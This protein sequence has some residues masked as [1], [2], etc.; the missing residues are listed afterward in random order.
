MAERRM[1]AASIVESDA[2]RMM[3]IDAQALYFH[4]NSSADDDGFVNNVI[5]IQRAIGA[6]PEAVGELVDRKFLISFPSGVYVIKHWLINN[7]IR[8]DRY[9]KTTYTK[10]MA[11]LE[12]E[13]G[14]KSY[15]IIHHEEPTGIPN[16][17][18]VTPDGSQDDSKMETEVRLDK[19]SNNTSSL[20]SE[21]C[22]SPTSEAVNY[23]EIQDMF[24]EI[25]KDLPSI[26]EMTEQR[27]RKVKSFLKKRS[28][29]E[30]RSF[31]MKVE[32]SDFLTGRDGKWD[33]CSFDWI[34]KPEN[35][36]KIIEGN[37]DNA[38]KRLSRKKMVTDESERLKGVNEDGSF[39]LM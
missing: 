24:N 2:F 37:Y 32:A 4:L 15:R 16:D 19:D 33:N 7:T 11:Q 18:H 22:D 10:E 35:I 23:Q 38:K 26:R 3:S 27:K 5:S 28:L 21:V 34:T 17:N 14:N 6:K 25:C 39:S 1:V 20:R 13:S 30:L 36:Q 9:H 29:D 8:T 31:F 12:V